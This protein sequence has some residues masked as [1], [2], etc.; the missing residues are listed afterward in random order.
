MLIVTYL[1]AKWIEK[2]CPGNQYS[3]LVKKALKYIEK[4]GDLKK[5]SESYGKYVT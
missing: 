3:L 4:N 2:H 5:I 1:V